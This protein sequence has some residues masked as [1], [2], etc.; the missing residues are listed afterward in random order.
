MPNMNDNKKSMQD[1]LTD[2]R[3]AYRLVYLYQERLYDIIKYIRRSMGLCHYRRERPY[4]T[5]KSSTDFVGRAVWD[6]IPF[7]N[8]STLLLPNGQDKDSLSKGEWMLDLHFL[9]DRDVFDESGWYVKDGKDRPEN[10]VPV[11]KSA[12]VL[13]IYLYQAKSDLK[14]EALQDIWCHNYWPKYEEK[15]EFKDDHDNK[16]VVYGKEFNLECL[17]NEKELKEVLDDFKESAREVLRLKK[18]FFPEFDG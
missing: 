3:R 14:L 8:F 15:H 9:A 7:Y 17:Q 11:E 6:G 10:F 12:S 5:G 16:V 13:Q 2:V 4:D 1:A 18:N